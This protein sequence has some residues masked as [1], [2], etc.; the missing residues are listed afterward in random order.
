LHNVLALLGNYPHGYPLRDSGYSNYDAHWMEFMMLGFFGT[1]FVVSQMAL[2]AFNQPPEF[3]MTVGLFAA[4][5]WIFHAIK[6]RDNWLMGVNVCV[7]GFALF[8]L[9]VN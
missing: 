7:F 2:L 3:A 9:I 8:G 1:V 4:V 6:N 5:C